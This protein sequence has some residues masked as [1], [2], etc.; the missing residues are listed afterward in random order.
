MTTSQTIA[1]LEAIRANLLA[2]FGSSDYVPG[3]IQDAADDLADLIAEL[4][5]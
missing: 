5:R 4:K 2:P 3:G 1:R